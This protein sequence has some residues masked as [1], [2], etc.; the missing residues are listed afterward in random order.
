VVNLL[1]SGDDEVQT[2]GKKFVRDFL[3][4]SFAETKLKS[5]LHSCRLGIRGCVA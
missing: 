2:G 1:I 4:Q 3:F 5:N